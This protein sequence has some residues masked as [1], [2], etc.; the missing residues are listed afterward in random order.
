MRVDKYGRNVSLRDEMADIIT[1]AL[2]HD[3]EIEQV[4]ESFLNSKDMDSM[5]DDILGAVEEHINY[6]ID[7]RRTVE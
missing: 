3:A 7:S 1:D 6:N 5:L 2:P 4:I